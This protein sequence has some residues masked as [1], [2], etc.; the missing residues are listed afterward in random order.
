MTTMDTTSPHPSGPSERFQSYHQ[1]IDESRRDCL[2]IRLWSLDQNNQ[3]VLIN[4]H[5]YFY[6]C[7]AALPTFLQNKNAREDL[8]LN[9]QNYL[10]PRGKRTDDWSNFSYSFERRK[11]FYGYSTNSELFLRMEFPNYEAMSL[12]RER[13]DSGKLKM[14]GYNKEQEFKCPVYEHNISPIRKLFTDINMPVASWFTISGSKLVSRDKATAKCREF[15]VNWKKIRCLADAQFISQPWTMSYD[16]E[17]YSD[18]DSEFPQALT[19]S[20]IC[21]MIS[22]TFE[23]LGDPETR[24]YYCIY[25]GTEQ[26]IVVQGNGQKV[27]HVIPVQYESELLLAFF[28]LIERENPI[29]LTGYNL[30]GFD[31]NYLNARVNL[32][33]L[34]IKNPGLLLET[35]RGFIKPAEEKSFMSKSES[36]LLTIPGRITIDM[37]DYMKRVYPGLTKHSLEFVS[38]KFIQSSKHDISAVQ[39]FRAYRKARQ[40]QLNLMSDEIIQEDEMPRVDLEEQECDDFLY[41]SSRKD[42]RT[43]YQTWLED[44]LFRIETFWLE[45]EIDQEQANQALIEYQ[46]VI[47]YCVQ[48][49]I[50]PLMLMNKL[51]VWTAQVEL[52]NLM[53]VP[54]EDLLTQG[55][56]ARC[57]S[58]VYDLFHQAGFVLKPM[59]FENMNAEGGLVTHP[60][61]GLHENVVLMDFA[62]LYPSIIREFNISLETIVWDENIPEEDCLITEFHQMEIQPDPLKGNK[63]PNK[64]TIRAKEL[65]KQIDYRYR[66]IKKETYHGILPKLME[67]LLLERNKLRKNIK[68]MKP[69]HD[70]PST[71]V[72]RVKELK[73]LMS[74]YEA[75]QLAMKVSMNAIYGF[76]KVRKGAKLAFPDGARAITAMGRQH[77]QECNWWMT[78]G[79]EELIGKLKP[80]EIPSTLSE[81]DLTIPCQILYNDTDSCFVKVKHIQAIHLA[82]YGHM[83]QQA[84]RHVFD[85]ALTLE[86]EKTLAVILLVSKKRYSGYVLDDKT[87]L[88]A[89]D[90]LTG[91]KENYTRGLVTAKRDGAAFMRDLFQDVCNMILDQSKVEVVLEEIFAR[92][93]QLLSG[94]VPIEQL[95]LMKKIGHEYK[96]NTSEMAL[97]KILLGERGRPVNPGEKIDFLMC[98]NR[99]DLIKLGS[100]RPMRDGDVKIGERHW[101][102]S[103]VQEGLSPQIDFL[104]YLDKMATCIDQIFSIAF[105]DEKI[106]E[107][108]YY[109]KNRTRTYWN[110]LTP[111]SYCARMGFDLEEEVHG[112]INRQEIVACPNDSEKNEYVLREVRTAL[113]EMME[114]VLQVLGNPTYRRRLLGQA[115]PGQGQTN[116]LEVSSDSDD[117]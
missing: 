63:L 107:H 42:E 101:M 110:M 90:K 13:L 94:Q 91:K 77:I 100:K 22:C 52:S 73:V 37:F 88:I 92:I 23:H 3:A 39:M 85:E 43:A 15:N 53:G 82:D 75:R 104:L 67:K 57:F 98:I 24:K 28:N 65:T 1:E 112:R 70:D 40:V 4:V 103:E 87:G 11:G 106:L 99:K 5:D 69:E 25:I 59:Y 6:S 81:Y 109:Q 66:W 71:P 83:L 27:V 30:G 61:V 97:F 114:Q 31:N 12:A 19:P 46:K 35:K 95:S 102:V 68:I 17:V 108:I 18:K 84:F 44:K 72:E 34:R 49:T 48:D 54:I 33:R 116:V 56:Q 111:M 47:A 74:I 16:I 60:E 8:I 26:D 20:C 7:Y 80:Q 89:M 14:P 78:S 36:N 51:D 50:L 113:R 115:K 10:K 62:S 38:N 117:E 58:Q 45:E 105:Q 96:N 2:I 93:D 64:G 9:I 32:N 86:Y 29:V 79:I 41:V 76:L 21:Y 55:E